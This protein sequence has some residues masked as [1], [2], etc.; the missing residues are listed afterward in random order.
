MSVPWYKRRVLMVS[1]ALALVILAFC[2]ARDVR[3][4][5]WVWVIA[6]AAAFA[7]LVTFLVW[8]R[9]SSTSVGGSHRSLSISDH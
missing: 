1:S 7:G 3:R 6:E 4:D 5:E 2:L 9:R 8:G